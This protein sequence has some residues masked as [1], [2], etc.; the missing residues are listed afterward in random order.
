MTLTLRSLFIP[1]AI[2]ASCAPAASFFVKDLEMD[3]RL[4]AE[5]FESTLIDHDPGSNYGNWT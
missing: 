4:G 1:C 3:W 5:W 2:C